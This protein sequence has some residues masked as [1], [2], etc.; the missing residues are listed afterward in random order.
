MSIN[1]EAEVTTMMI[2]INLGIAH[3]L[4][5]INCI[6]LVV[7]LVLHGLS[8]EKQTQQHAASQEL[9]PKTALSR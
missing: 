8:T 9:V 3:V 4:E 6:K 5:K 7:Y 1:R 2:I